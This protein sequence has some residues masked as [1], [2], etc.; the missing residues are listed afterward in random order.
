MTSK[1]KE[2]LIAD[3]QALATR[4]EGFMTDE[5]ECEVGDLIDLLES[6]ASAVED[7]ESD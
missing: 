1:D 3:I 5:N 6:A 2:K 4:A 7:I